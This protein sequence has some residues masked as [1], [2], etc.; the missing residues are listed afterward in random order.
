MVKT[1]KVKKS[2][3]TVTVQLAERYLFKDKREL[4]LN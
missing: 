1:R 4:L 3:S 2:F